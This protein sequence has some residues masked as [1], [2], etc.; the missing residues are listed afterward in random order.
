IAYFTL[1]VAPLDGLIAFFGPRFFTSVGILIAAVAQ[2]ALFVD[3]RESLM[4]SLLHARKITNKM[5]NRRMIIGG[6]SLTLV[7]GVAVS[8]LAMLALCYK[9]GIRELQLDWATRTTVAVYE[10]IHSLVESPVRPG[11]WVMVFSVM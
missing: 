9:F 5:V 7:V 8:F 3:L 4:P 11:H 2:K 6:I 10:N 1:T